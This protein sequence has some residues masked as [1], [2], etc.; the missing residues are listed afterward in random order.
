MKIKIGVLLKRNYRDLIIVFL[1]FFIMAL[2]AYFSIGRILKTRLWA[3]ADEMVSTA[4]ANVRAG[5]SE[6]ETILLN[7]YHIVKGMIEQN[8]SKEEIL[9]YL[10][11]TTDWMRE[12]NSGLITFDGLFGYI[13]WEFYDSISFNP[14][15][16]FIPQTR[17]WYH[18]A[19]RAG[20]TAAYTAPY[21]DARTGDTVISAVKNIDL[22]NGE[23][24]GILVADIK[25]N[26]LVDF[27]KS[28]SLAKNGYGMLL[29]QNMTLMAHPDSKFT[30]C[31]LHELGGSYSEIAFNLYSKKEVYGRRI[32]NTK[33]ISEIVFFS[34][35]FND[36]YIGIVTHYYNFYFDLYIAAAI[37]IVLG[38][39]FSL[40]LSYI[41]LYF[42]AARIR[43]DE[44]SLSLERVLLKTMAELVERRDDIT[45]GHIDRTQR[46]IKILLDEVQKSGV[47]REKTKDWNIDLLIQSSQLHDIGK[48]SIE[49]RILKK[50]GKLNDDEYTE[51]KNHTTFGEQ[52]IA[53][54]QT[55]TEENEFLKYAKIFAASH[56]ERWDGTGYPKGLKENEIPLLGR[57]MAIADVYDALVSE[58]PYKKAFSHK[59]A[60][61]IIKDNKDKQFDPFLIDMFMAVSDMFKMIT[62]EKQ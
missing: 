39:I 46:G 52:I 13:N 17:P 62:A 14:D 41:L 22:K 9:K 23:T 61:R 37:L 55:M 60:I 10:T 15:E 44:K 45:G 8:A 7:S 11:D 26:W 2:A 27:V 20:N 21:T 29:N 42:S 54:I 59:E 30:G 34:R 58:R 35:I 38:I 43:A 4:E 53:K 28:L 57:I 36:W 1:T 49:D 47:Y 25:I 56:H 48:I 40:S 6:A 3:R 16:T 32:T 19:L 18:T 33:G 31:Q 5:L 24:A 12:R 50:P 51:M